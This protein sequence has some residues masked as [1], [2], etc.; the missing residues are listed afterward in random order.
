[1]GA[2]GPSG[3]SG[4]GPQELGFTT[5]DKRTAKQKQKD[6][7]VEMGL[8]K[9]RM[10]NYSVADGGTKTGGGS[11]NNNTIKQVTETAPTVSEVSQATTAEADADTKANRLLKIKKKGRSQSII[12]GSQ[13]VTKTSTD[14]SLGKKSLLGQV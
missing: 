8:G 9:N 2:S 14:Y 1:M 7:N 12:S 10:S 11:D 4:T 3:G 13:G 6:A 5:R